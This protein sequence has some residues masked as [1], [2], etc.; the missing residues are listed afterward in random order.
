[1]SQWL[2]V[3]EDKELERCEIKPI[4]KPPATPA[5]IPIN[6]RI[7]TFSISFDLPYFAMR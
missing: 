5:R 4:A 6:A 3:E 2:E 7:N 1:M